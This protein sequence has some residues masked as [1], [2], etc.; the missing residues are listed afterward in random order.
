[1][2][3][4]RGGAGAV[5][6]CV[7]F[8]F[9]V[10]VEGVGEIFQYEDAGSLA[11]DEAVSIAVEGAGREVRGGVVGCGEGFCAGEAGE[12]EWVDAGF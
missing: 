10:A 12:G 2:V 4:V 6:F 7:D 8:G 9:G 1:M 5:E 11:D 3:G